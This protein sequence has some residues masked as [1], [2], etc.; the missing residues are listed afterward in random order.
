MIVDVLTQFGVWP[1]RNIDISSSMLLKLM[2][3]NGVEKACTISARGIFY[4]FAVSDLFINSKG[5]G[6]KGSEQNNQ[7]TWQIFPIYT[8][9]TP[10]LKFPRNSSSDHA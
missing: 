6:Q 1:R 7:N 5:N 9:A 10:E 2:G 3:N 4:D 8:F